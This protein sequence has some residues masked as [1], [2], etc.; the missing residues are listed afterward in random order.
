MVPEEN[1][2][3][4]LVYD[5]FQSASNLP[6][7]RKESFAAVSIAATGCTATSVYFCHNA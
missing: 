5:A 3:T 1:Q 7:Y 6:T 4:L 2:S